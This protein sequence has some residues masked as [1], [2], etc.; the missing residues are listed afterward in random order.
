MQLVTQKVAQI[1]RKKVHP[2]CDT[3]CSTGELEISA[4]S[5]NRVNTYATSNPENS[6]LKCNKSR[7][8]GELEI[9]AVTPVTTR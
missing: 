8:T 7:S 2:D 1:P 6:H 3:D 9:S 5:D 4:D